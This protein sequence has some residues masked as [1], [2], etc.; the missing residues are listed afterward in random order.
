MKCL[1]RSELICHNRKP[2]SV[3]STSVTE[4]TRVRGLIT[5]FRI[6]AL[7]TAVSLA[8]LVPFFVIGEDRGAGCCGGSM[9]VTHDMAMHLNQMQGFYRGL[10]S[11]RLYPRW[12]E[13]TNRG[14]GA[15]TTI[16][17]PP[18]LYYLSSV[19][20]FIFRGWMTAI[21]VLT[22]LLMISAGLAI[23]QLARQFF[24]Q[25]ASIVGMSVYLIAPYH[26]LDYYQRGALAECLSFTW[27]PLTAL[28][29]VRLIESPS[30][31]PSVFRDV[32]GLALSWG[33]FILSHPPTAYQFALIMG[34]VL[35]LYALLGRRWKQLL[36]AAL[37]V[38]LGCLLAAA[39][40][41]P[42]IVERRYVQVEDVEKT[43][44]YHESYVWFFDSSRY[45]HIGDVFTIRLDRI[46]LF[47]LIAIVV[48]GLCLLLLNKTKA[49]NGSGPD[50]TFVLWLIAGVYA[51]CM[52]LAL[53]RI[54]GELI[55][56]IEIGVFAWRM[57]AMTSM[58]LAM[59]TGQLA[60]LISHDDAR[61]PWRRRWL[62]SVVFGVFVASAGVSL[63][64]V[65][66]P[67]YRAEAF[68]PRPHHSNYALTPISGTREPPS[69][70]EVTL[71]NPA[72][73]A[74][75]ER[76]DP[77]SRSIRVHLDAPSTVSFR[78]FN[79]PGW[80]AADAGIP[81]ATR[82]GPDGEISV[83]IAGGEHHLTLEFENTPI[84]R[85]SVLI[86]LVALIMFVVGALGRALRLKTPLQRLREGK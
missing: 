23:F 71:S 54:V 80:I 2:M 13:N 70:D 40:I 6:L 63:A 69:R 44:P 53:S 29:A 9:P 64:Y 37:G 27:M 58:T 86:S 38:V 7:C 35:V 60:E 56:E 81:V 77:E 8:V 65:I 75:V 82:T 50:R 3:P 17:Y 62:G 33:L 5:H 12:Q 78:T 26:I 59:L 46:W 1:A 19:L 41:L 52:M 22:L 4:K 76:W 84:R 61:S 85:L 32:A 15:P 47:G 51:S 25:A 18:A 21:R 49:R 28:F 31:K 16:F 43:W 14:F 68:K 10:E 30:L 57:L 45:D 48:V 20:F 36:P 79:Y 39:Y 34:P 73:R 67:M 24:S 72:G 42:A 66:V 83:D 74:T 55:P 11:G